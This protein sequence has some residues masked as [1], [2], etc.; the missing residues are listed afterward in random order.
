[1]FKK[2]ICGCDCE[3]YFDNL[4][5]SLEEGFLLCEVLYNNEGEDLDF[6]ILEINKAYETMFGPNSKDIVGKTVNEVYPDVAPKWVD[7]CKQVVQN[8]ESIQSDIHFEIKDK[9]F[10]INV[11]TPAKGQIITLFNDITE[12]IKADEVLKKHFI[13]FENAHDILLYLK[14][15][16]SI[17]DANK[18]AVIKYGYSYIE[19]LNMNVKQIRHPSMMGEYEGQMEVSASKGIIFECIHVTKDGTSFPVEVSSRSIDINDELI[20]I[21]IIRDITERK[22]AEEKIR[23]LANYDALT[24]ISN[25]G[26]LMQQFEKT[27]EQAKRSNSMFS[28]ML[29]DV[30]KF[31]TI[32]DVYGHNAGDE[33]LRKV[34][35]RLRAVLREADIIGRLGGDEFL[36]I[37]PFINDK[38]ECSVLAKKILDDV[39]KPI[40]W[41]DAALDVRLSIGIAVF[42]QDSV[43]SKGLIQY[44]DNAMYAIKQ[45]GGNNYNFGEGNRYE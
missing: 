12:I 40:Q 15:D 3:K 35:K 44:A 43:D 30:D 28:V 6:R 26:F 21:H 10:R 4:F 8:G 14:A 18:T 42:P 31:K 11:L 13:L 32:N 16:G 34:S 38:E 45:R 25:R 22:Q 20:R 2:Y 17:I 5:N 36:V 7:I 23:Y 24:G 37:R 9:H 27:L 33:V 19:L 1:M 29:F 39:A 41:E